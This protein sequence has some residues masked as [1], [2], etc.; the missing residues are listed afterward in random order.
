MSLTVACVFSSAVPVSAAT[1]VPVAKYM[2]LNVNNEMLLSNTVTMPH[3]KWFDSRPVEFQGR[4]LRKDTST[5]NSIYPQL[6]LQCIQ[7]EFLTI[8]FQPIRISSKNNIPCLHNERSTASL[9]KLE[10][11]AV[12]VFFD[13]DLHANAKHQQ[14]NASHKHD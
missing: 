3:G 14:F 9:P 1:G 10:R 5:G 4:Y 13:F 7:L 8:L 11:K 6:G 2:K 12:N